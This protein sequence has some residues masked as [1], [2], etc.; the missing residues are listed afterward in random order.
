VTLIG[1][2][3]ITWRG[4]PEPDALRDIQ[5]AGYD[6]A[7]PRL[8]PERSAGETIELYGRYGLRPAPPYLGAPLW[9]RES[10]DE[11]V[12]AARGAARLSRELGCDELYVAANGAYEAASGRSRSQAAGHVGPADAMT[13]GELRTFADTLGMVGEATL[14]TGVRTCFHNHVGTVIETVE[15]VERLLTLTDPAVVFLGPDTGH[16]A[17]AGD[18]PVMFCARH[19]ERIL[20]LHLKDIDEGVRLR[21]REEGWDYATFSANG[22]FAEM[23]EGG[24]DFPGLLSL[25]RHGGFDG[26]LI[27]ETDVTRKPTPLESATIS[28]RYLRSLG[29]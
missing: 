28:R 8:D 15:E 2:G 25:L 5:Q 12:A 9:R 16:L 14:N 20:T 10:R 21:G 3:Q 11:I 18:D 17:W 22:I 29:L 19:R 7:P 13:A 26:W 4:F 24:V 1:C 23:G 6:G 27:V